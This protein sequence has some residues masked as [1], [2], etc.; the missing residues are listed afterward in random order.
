MNTLVLS[1]ASGRLSDLAV[2][3]GLGLARWGRRRAAR[4]TDRDRLLRR[5][6]ERSAAEAA[7]AERD[8]VI[9]TG[10]FLPL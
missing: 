3:T 6:A 7:L 9:R 5:M 1:P 4:R 8:R 10:T 2:R